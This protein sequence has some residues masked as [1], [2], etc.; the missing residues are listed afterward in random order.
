MHRRRGISQKAEKPAALTAWGA[1]PGLA[2]RGWLAGTWTWQ[3]TD[4]LS[5]PDNYLCPTFTANSTRAPQV[6]CEASWWG[7]SSGGCQSQEDQTAP[8]QSCGSLLSGRR[9][10]GG[11][12]DWNRSWDVGHVNKEIFFPGIHFPPPSHLHNTLPCTHHFYQPQSSTE[13][14]DD[15]CGRR[16]D[17]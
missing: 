2:L 9:G 13:S 15:A 11:W 1:S 5:C 12:D 16:I 4:T 3:S 8:E 7:G 14:C 17:Q 6:V 10:R